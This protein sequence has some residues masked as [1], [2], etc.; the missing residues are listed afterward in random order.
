[1]AEQES[2][3]EQVP[4]RE[5]VGPKQGILSRVKGLVGVLAKPFGAKAS[6][7]GTSQSSAL[8]TAVLNIHKLD[9]KTVNQILGLVLVG[10]IAL[11]SYYGFSEH[12]TI[13]ALTAAVSRIQYDPP[14]ETV[15]VPFE[16]LSVYQEEFAKRNIF[17]EYEE[18]KPPP[19][20]PPVVEEVAP[21][22]PPPPPKVTIQEKAKNLKL[23]G[24]SWGS[25]PKAMI[26]NQSSG[27]VLF[28]E[29]GQPIKGTE[30]KIK[31]IDVQGVII[32]SDGDEMKML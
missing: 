32:E 3:N 16:E 6:S 25:A 12:P 18:Y 11:A 8:M 14:E 15:I 7:G 23:M 2:G 30:I 27:E 4:K 21:P 29:Q 17:K 20:P 31:S 28:L 9:L 5:G 1:M 19:P 22:P 10:L 24:V 26:Q 13:E